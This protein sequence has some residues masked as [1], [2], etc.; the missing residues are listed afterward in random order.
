PEF[1]RAA[2]D[3]R[4]AI[5]IGH[6]FAAKFRSGV[7]YAAYEQTGDRMGIELALRHYRR[8]RDYWRDFS[9][10]AK[11]AYVSDI[12][13]GTAP[14]QRGNWLDRLPAIDDDIAEMQKRLDSAP[15]SRTA[16]ASVYG[17]VPIVEPRE[18]AKLQHK[19]ATSF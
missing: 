4:I 2:I 10:D 8:A 15:P 12:T 6:F 18:L 1:R 19:P 3:L 7:M 9:E 17:L 11:S 13:F 14:H 16:S 5:G